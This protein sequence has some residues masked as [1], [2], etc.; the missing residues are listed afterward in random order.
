[1]SAAEHQHKRCQ[2]LKETGQYDKY[3]EK[4]AT[5]QQKYH[6]RQDEKEEKLPLD[7]I[8]KLIKK[9]WEK[10]CKRVAKHRL[11]KTIEM[12][13]KHEIEKKQTKPFNSFS[14][15]AKATTRAQY[16]IEQALPKTPNRTKR[17][18]LPICNTKCCC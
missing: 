1:M 3:K 8:S 7:E 9:K 12:G 18:F 4:H 10:C 11:L 15:L 5:D 14:A 16:A 13:E 17:A 2:K 6:K